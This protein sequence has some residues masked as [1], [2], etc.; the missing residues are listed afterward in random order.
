[1]QNDYLNE[2]IEFYSNKHNL[3]IHTIEK[4]IQKSF[5]VFG[6]GGWNGGEFA[7]F[8]DMMNKAMQWKY[9]TKEKNSSFFS[10]GGIDFIK[11]YDYMQDLDLMRMLSYSLQRGQIV[12]NVAYFAEF[13]MHKY[14]ESNV[15]DKIVVVDYGCGLAY[16]TIA[17]CELLIEK[18]IPVELILIDIYRKSFVEFLDY[19]CKKRKINYQ[20]KEVKHDKLI[21]EIPECDYVH[22]MAVLEH[23][24]EPEKIIESI[25]DSIRNDGIIFGTFYDDPFEDFEHISYDLSG[26]RNILENNKKYNIKNHGSY[27]NEETTVY[28]VFKGE[29]YVL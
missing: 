5:E 2:Y 18:D 3:K 1:M 15:I 21:P 11:C 27:W 19:L 10:D 26:A 4:H 29:K 17:I 24:S 16:W 14:E 23:T 22:I 20:F 7:E 8:T 12:D 13:L 9:L 6:D 25:V 28:Q